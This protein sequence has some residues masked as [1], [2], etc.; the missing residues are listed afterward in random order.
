MRISPEAFVEK[1]KGKTYEELLVVRDELITVIKKYEAE[2][3]HDP[4]D[5]L[6]YPAQD[7][8]YY[9]NLKLLGGLCNLIADKFGEKEAGAQ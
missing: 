9:C 1:N 8:N 6:V 2:T 3:E 7:G 5:V 4:E